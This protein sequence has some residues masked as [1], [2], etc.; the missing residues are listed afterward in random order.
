MSKKARKKLLA[1]KSK[2]ISL[3]G[4][5]GTGKTTDLAHFIVDKLQ[6]SS[7]RV[8][9]LT[10]TKSAAAE[11]K[12]KIE[13][14]AASAHVRLAS[15]RVG[16]FHSFA[17]SHLKRWA[18]LLGFTNNFSVQNRNREILQRLTQGVAFAE[19]SN[20]IE[21]LAT[22]NA[23]H[24]RSGSKS[25]DIMKSQTEKQD[26]TTVLRVLKTLR[27]NKKKANSMDFDD[28]IFCFHKLLL[29]NPKVLKSIGKSLSWLVV[30]EFQDITD[31]QWKIISLLIKEGV[32]FLGAGDRFQTLYQFSGASLNRFDQLE[33]LA[34]CE[35][36]VRN[37][38]HRNT[39]PIAA[40]SNAM[41]SNHVSMKG[42][43]IKSKVDG[44]KPQV[45]LSPSK[46]LL[47]R[48][49]LG[50][51][52]HHMKRDKLGLDRMAVTFRFDNDAQ[53][54]VKMLTT[55]RIPY[56]LHSKERRKPSVI[57]LVKAIMKIASGQGNR[58]TWKMILEHL[59]GVGEKKASKIANE[60]KKSKF[61]ARALKAVSRNYR[62]KA[63][64]SLVG[65]FSS[66]R[67][68]KT[69]PP[70]AVD[71]VISF[72]SAQKKIKEIESY[73]PA[74][75]TIAQISSDTDEFLMNLA[76]EHLEQRH[77][78]GDTNPQGGFLTVGNIH[79]LK[80]KQFHVV[81]ILG[82]YDTLFKHHKTFKHPERV[83]EE[84]FVMNVALTRSSRRL[85]VLLPMSPP[86]WSGKA[87]KKNPSFFIRECP[88]KTHKLLTLRP[89]PK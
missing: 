31:V 28:M 51:I 27:R 73:S 79:Q 23:L 69:K 2:V 38:T 13:E 6:H 7:K 14:V 45:I 26:Q 83:M 60:L 49:I 55:E 72:L 56:I 80:G 21:Q 37:L 16:T 4:V 85:Y 9:A 81:F 36:F 59:E 10:L 88:H 86:D 46:G 68:R 87:R 42:Y 52:R 62:V 89:T 48:A 58:E 53:T 33:S 71:A 19:L 67:K 82:S 20:P 25:K 54:L 34:G 47:C 84:V 44:P 24:M 77:S 76:D 41:L 63:L 15:L 5:A 1:C 12:A 22:I 35:K 39:K 64:K 65:L 43:E 18:H 30:D 75:R 57:G 32:R 11:L 3:S 78:F 40:L 61:E 29:D 74:L 8:V 70:E 17:F 66:L 50:K